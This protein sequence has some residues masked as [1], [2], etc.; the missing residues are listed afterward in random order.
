MDPRLDII[1][2]LNTLFWATDHH[3]GDTLAHVFSDKVTLDYG[4]TEMLSQRKG[5][6]RW[7]PEFEGRDAHQHLVSNHLITL[8]DD[9]ATATASFIATHQHAHGTWTLGGDYRF[10]LHNTP[11]G[12]KVTVMEMRPVWE[13]GVGIG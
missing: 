1:T 7:R 5:S 3:G 6:G 11:S 2:T 12:W 4:G 10:S 8:R 13:E 9:A